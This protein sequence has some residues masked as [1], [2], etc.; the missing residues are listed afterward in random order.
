M[1][2][3][4]Y[5]LFFVYETS[6]RITQFIKIRIIICNAKQTE[7]KIVFK[8]DHACYIGLKFCELSV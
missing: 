5:Q 4:G 3:Q 8:L 2:N 7:D 6:K 1:S